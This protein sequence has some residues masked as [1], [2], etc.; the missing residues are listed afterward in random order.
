[1]AAKYINIE[2]AQA[3]KREGREEK[4][5]ESKDEG[6]SKKL[7]LDFKDK[8]PSWQMINTVY[9]LLTIPITQALMAVEDKGL[10]SRP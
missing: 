4:R 7:R 9:T 5:K 1:M 10:L 6:P 3:S 8:K 2:D